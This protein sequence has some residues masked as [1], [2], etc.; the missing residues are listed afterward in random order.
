MVDNNIR[1]CKEYKLKTK[2]ENFK[3]IFGTTNRINPAVVYIKI[4]T[5]AKYVGD[6]KNY[7]NNV[8]NLNSV[9]RNKVKQE[10][11]AIDNFTSS[12]FYTPNIKKI[13]S[14]KENSFHVCFEITLK[15]R[16]PILHKINLLN[17]KI[18]IITNLLI[19]SIEENYNFEFSKKKW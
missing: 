7:N 19:D 16:D 9:V 8:N 4:N 15:Q 1:L 13:L 6:I 14:N 18:E 11:N 2:S 3:C 17:D 10:L 5:W 12:F